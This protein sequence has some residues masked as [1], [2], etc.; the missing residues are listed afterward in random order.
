MTIK[1]YHAPLAPPLDYHSSAGP[2]ATLMRLQPS[3]NNPNV[4]AIW[5]QISDLALP[6]GSATALVRGVGGDQSLRWVYAGLLGLIIA[7]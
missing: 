3:G 6:L 1:S 2:P 7:G 5:P 4:A